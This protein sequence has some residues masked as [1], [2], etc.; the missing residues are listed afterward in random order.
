M[1]RLLLTLGLLA[2][3]VLAGLGL[4]WGWRSRARRQVESL[5]LPE[6]PEPPADLGTELADP[7]AGLYVSTTTAGHWQDRVVDKGL[8][9]RAAAE[10]RLHRR[11][12]LIDRTGES[13]IFIP[14]EAI[15]AVGTQPGIAGKVMGMP[16]GVLVITWTHGGT[17][18]DTGVRVN[19]L[20]AQAEWIVAARQ[21]TPAGVA[22]HDADE[23]DEK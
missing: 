21:L 5:A 2:L 7:L 17:A 15:T 18:L 12:V 23:R 10:L 19:D 13:T 3:C 4:L 20:A 6:L 1:D 9:R 11:G 16:Q 22:A 8:G 14:A